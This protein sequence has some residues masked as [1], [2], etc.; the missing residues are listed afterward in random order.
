MAVLQCEKMPSSEAFLSGSPGVGSTESARIAP[1]S[2]RTNC[3]AS[4]HSQVHWPC[5]SCPPPAISCRYRISPQHAP[6][7][8]LCAPSKQRPC[9]CDVP[10]SRSRSCSASLTPNEPLGAAL[11]GTSHISISSLSF[12]SSAGCSSAGSTHSLAPCWHTSDSSA[13]KCSSSSNSDIRME[14]M[15]VSMNATPTSR[16]LPAYPLEPAV[17]PTCTAAMMGDVSA[18]G[19]SRSRPHSS[20]KAIR[21]PGEPRR[22]STHEFLSGRY[23]STRRRCCSSAVRITS[24][25]IFLLMLRKEQRSPPDCTVLTHAVDLKYSTATVSASRPTSEK[26]SFLSKNRSMSSGCRPAFAR[27]AVTERASWPSSSSFDMLVE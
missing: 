11:L 17:L 26:Y 19:S 10:S 25:A 7:E 24:E 6:S 23:T 16:P 21:L 2:S 27:K 12:V 13:E 5:D 3:D 8:S 18:L 1:A 4:T 15:V 14:R 22:C 20:S 9:S